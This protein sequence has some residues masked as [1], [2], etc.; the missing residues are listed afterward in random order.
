VAQAAASIP[1][2]I[3]IVSG[4]CAYSLDPLGEV[5][6]LL[7]AALER[8]AHAIMEAL[9]VNPEAA[10]R[11][12][13]GGSAISDARLVSVTPLGNGVHRLTVITPDSFAGRYLDFSRDTPSNELL[14]RTPTANNINFV[15]EH[16]A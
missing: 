12:P 11:T 9:R 7:G 10:F 16:N 13:V 8:I 2:D 1:G 4:W 3:D 15:S 14:L 5:E 6:I